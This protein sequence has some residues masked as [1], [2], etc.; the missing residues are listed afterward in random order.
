MEAFK[1]YVD[2]YRFLT[3]LLDM[4][5]YELNLN[6]FY[7]DG[8]HKEELKLIDGSKE[9]NYHTLMF[10]LPDSYDFKKEIYIENSLGDKVLLRIGLITTT[11][12][13]DY[14]FKYDGPLGIS[15]TKKS[16]IFRVWSPTS[17]KMNLILVR[18][19]VEERLAFKYKFKG[20]WEIK[21]LGDLENAKYLFETFFEDKSFITR[22][23]YAI[24]SDEKYNIV[25]DFNKTKKMKY[26]K[27]EFSSKPTDAIIYEAS[28]R[29]FSYNSLENNKTF[30][31]MI[32]RK[33][34]YNGEKRGIDYIASL[35]VT[36]LQLLPT[37][38]FGGVNEIQKDDYNWGYNPLEYFVVSGYY[39]KNPS[40]PYSRIDELKEIIDYSH[41]R[42][43]RVVMDVVY[44]HVY[45]WDK[46]P[47]NFLCPNYFYRLEGR[48]QANATGCG[49][50]VASE[51]YMVRRFIIDNLKF[52]A[53]NFNVSGFRFDLMG[54]LDTTTLNLAYNEIKKIEPGVIMYGEGWNM[55]SPLHEELRGSMNNHYK[56]LNY[57][58]FN[59]NFRDYVRG[60]K[61]KKDK[62]VAFERGKNK[63]EIF[64]LFRGSS[65]YSYKFS[66]PCQSIN[67]VECHDNH[68]FYDFGRYVLKCRDE[69]I[70]DAAKMALSLIVLSEGIPFIHA[71]EEFLGTKRGVENSY[72]SPDIINK[73]NYTRRNQNLDLINT[74]RD[75]I[76]IRKTFGAFRYSMKAEVEANVY[77]YDNVWED[78]ITKIYLKDNVD[79][80]VV[81]IKYD[82]KEDEITLDNYR[83]I[84]DTNRRCD[85]NY[86]TYKL[87]D[88]GIYVFVKNRY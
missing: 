88:K 85:N 19:G 5:L 18:N 56:L 44:N 72:K 49:N 83:M 86:S 69:D 11:N 59:D 81:A 41:R 26:P 71:G 64:D 24:A 58:F 51:R 82:K 60:N 70:K 10:K 47:Y 17:K 21:V 61:W 39:S 80:L 2:S 73:F 14:K 87:Y 77:E 78:D 20:V 22:D 32:D 12:Q 6:Y 75:L 57:G 29:D 31:G 30:E 68:T 33:V 66:N 37:Y 7:I 65:R 62:G 42:G 35:G 52:Y 8:N 13:F 55:D 16:T 23:P 76:W 46:F 40:D 45:Y 48:R 9:G 79:Q 53:K 84:F 15:Y 67:Y 50:T 63:Y 1:A 4:K 74:L 43:L 34:D 25:I 54:I 3:V 27:P 38:E 36:H 28:V